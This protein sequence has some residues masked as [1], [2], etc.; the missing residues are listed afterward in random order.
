MSH[1]RRRAARRFVALS[2][3]L[4]ACSG[5]SA[6]KRFA[7]AGW[8]RDGWQ[9]PDRVIA[10][11]DLEPGDRV[12]DLGAG[13]GYFTFRLA[14]AVGPSG[15]V[16]AV[17]VDEDMTEYL[18][19]RSAREGRG[20]VRVILAEYRD[21]LLPDGGVD[22][23]FTCNTYHHLQDRVTYFARVRRDLRP[24][25]RVA[26]VELSDASWFPRWFG[27]HT[28]LET[29]VGEMN[30]AGYR[31]DRSFDFLTRQHFAIFRVAS[32]GDTV[33]QP[34]AKAGSPTRSRLSA[35]SGT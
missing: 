16:F 34:A 19:A 32:D 17:D 21:P 33:H 22:L 28:P 18:A 7:Y 27:H 6:W 9:Q 2:L 8:G 12:A 13:G 3:A 20:N 15:V 30:A 24:G 14:D 29:I 11:L 31:L 5:C 1:G 4:A 10:A 35:V 23:L 25:G 26:I